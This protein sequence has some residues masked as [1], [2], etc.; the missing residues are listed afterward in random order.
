VL[1]SVCPASMRRGHSAVGGSR[2][3][4]TA[5]PTC[6]ITTRRIGSARSI[7]P[8][9][10]PNGGSGFSVH[11]CA[12]SSAGGARPHLTSNVAMKAR[13]LALKVPAH[14]HR[15]SA[16]S[17]RIRAPRLF[18]RPLTSSHV[19]DARRMQTC[20]SVGESGTRRPRQ[21][22]INGSNAMTRAPH[23]STGSSSDGASGL[24]QLEQQAGR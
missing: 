9:S 14:L 21:L 15:L 19:R 7:G 12:L 23:L 22:I 20:A 4:G 1:P 5:A 10:A 24:P 18:H 11:S 16:G 3:C 2:S 17:L 8:Q 6:S 13:S